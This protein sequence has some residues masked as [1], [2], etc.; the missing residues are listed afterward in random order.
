MIPFGKNTTEEYIPGDVWINLITGDI[1]LWGL[2]KMVSASFSIVK[3]LFFPLELI[4]ILKETLWD[5]VRILFLLKLFFILSNFFI[6]VKY[7]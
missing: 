2:V 1:N 4:N 5:Y 3:L 7:K 6:V